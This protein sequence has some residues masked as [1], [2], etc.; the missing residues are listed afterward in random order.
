MFRT[1]YAKVGQAMAGPVGGGDRLVAVTGATQGGLLRV[2]DVDA[3]GTPVGEP[4]YLPRNVPQVEMVQGPDGFLR[5]ASEVDESPEIDWAA[6]E[7]STGRIDEN[8]EVGE[9]ESIV[10]DGKVNPAMAAFKEL[11]GE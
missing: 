1:Y 4:T 6:H 3:T 8:E 9:D 7:S 5:E 10:S 11:Q 2:V